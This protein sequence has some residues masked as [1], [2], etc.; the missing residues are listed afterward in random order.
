[1]TTRGKT[2]ATTECT[3]PSPGILLLNTS[4]LLL[5]LI[6]CGSLYTLVIDM[7]SES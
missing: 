6:R 7:F 2:L 5:S 3:A 4:P 1:M